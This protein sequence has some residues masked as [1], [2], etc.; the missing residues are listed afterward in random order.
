M[1]SVLFAGSVT[2]RET[3]L[4]QLSRRRPLGSRRTSMPM[5][6]N[7]QTLVGGARTALGAAVVVVVVV[8]LVVVV[9]VD[10]VVCVVVELDNGSETTSYALH[11]PDKGL[12]VPPG[13]WRT[14]SNFSGGAAAL[15]F[16]SEEYDPTDYIRDYDEF[17]SW[18]QK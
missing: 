8:V 2:V 10:V 13:Y 6:G 15:V 17:V 3:A 11:S 16:A 12:R 14:L 9:V 1:S 4:S 7:G 18:S 5:F